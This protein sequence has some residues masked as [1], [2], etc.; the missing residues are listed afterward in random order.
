MNEKAKV[1]DPFGSDPAIVAMGRSDIKQQSFNPEVSPF[2]PMA[3]LGSWKVIAAEYTG[4]MKSKLEIAVNYLTTH[5]SRI[6]F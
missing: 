6:I 2:T 3:D 1:F 4:E 5:I